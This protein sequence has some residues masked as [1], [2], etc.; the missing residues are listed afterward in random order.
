MH[1]FKIVEELGVLHKIGVIT[2]DNASNNNTFMEELEEVLIE[3][4]IPFDRDGNR[5]RWED[6]LSALE[7]DL[8]EKCRSIVGTCRVSGQHRQALLKKIDEGNKSGYW[9]GKL[10]N[11]KDKIPLVQLLRDYETRWSSTYNMIECLLELYAAI[12]DFLLDLEQSDLQSLMLSELEKGVLYDIVQVLQVAHLAQELLLAPT[13]CMA[14]PVFETLINKWDHLS[15]TIPELKHVI[16]IGISKLEEYVAKTRKT[17][18]Y[19]LSMTKRINPSHRSATDIASS[20]I[21]HGYHRLKSLDVTVRRS[22][23]LH[24]L[25]SSASELTSP[26]PT[27]SIQPPRPQ[28]AAEIAATKARELVEDTAIVER[29]LSRYEAVS[30]LPSF[31]NAGMVNIVHF[32]SVHEFEYPLLFRVAMDVLPAQASTDLCIAKEA[33]YAISGQL[34]EAAIDELMAAGKYGE[35]EDLIKNMNKLS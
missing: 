14:L 1:F 9:K 8:V 23:S 27:S 34:T 26:P 21:S 24:S 30:A 35:L 29:K 18:T 28:T 4:G 31:E 15:S 33:D 32:W 13:L 25:Q 2:M 22:A 3:R 11:G 17:R 5:I 19:A 10:D 20:N 16:D 6:Y 7:A 12:H